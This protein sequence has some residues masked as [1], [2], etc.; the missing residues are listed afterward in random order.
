MGEEAGK[1]GV[2][3]DELLPE[4]WLGRFYAERKGK[5]AVTGVANA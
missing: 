1:A 3:R 4:Q 5:G 2:H